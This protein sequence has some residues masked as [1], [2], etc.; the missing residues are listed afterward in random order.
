MKVHFLYVK[1]EQ[2]MISMN[3][4]AI[5]AIFAYFYEN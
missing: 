2:K 3:I 4:N 1:K 5:N